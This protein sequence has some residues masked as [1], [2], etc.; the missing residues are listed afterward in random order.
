MTF[1]GAQCA[2]WVSI[3][4]N[5]TGYHYAKPF[6]TQGAKSHHLYALLVVH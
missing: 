3:W 4:S 6:S 1:P 5:Q 2:W